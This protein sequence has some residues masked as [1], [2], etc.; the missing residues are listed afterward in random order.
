M[1]FT[2]QICNAQG[3]ICHAERIS[4]F[5]EPYLQAIENIGEG[6]K[7]PKKLKIYISIEKIFPTNKEYLYC[8]SNVI[9][10][11][12]EHQTKC[13]LDDI[14]VSAD[15]IILNITQ[16]VSDRLKTQ[17]LSNGIEFFVSWTYTNKISTAAQK[18][19]KYGSIQLICP[20]GISRQMK[21]L[22]GIGNI[23]HINERLLIRAD[24]QNLN[25]IFSQLEYNT[26]D[27]GNLK[28]INLVNKRKTI[29]I[30][31]RDFPDRL[32]SFDFSSKEK[33]EQIISGCKGSRIVIIG[34][35]Q[36]K[37]F[38]VTSISGEEI[39]KISI[40]D[41]LKLQV[42]YNLDMILLGC[43]TAYQGATSGTL[44]TIRPKSVLERLKTT[45]NSRNAKDFLDSLSF[46]IF[47]FL[48]DETL[49]YN[50]SP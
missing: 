48:I 27:F 39:F 3:L 41:L 1:T 23:I 18:F 16:G 25:L 21:Y 28:V 36:D 38:S 7:N 10:S 24:L 6:S 11:G 34:H 22:R 15:D 47:K 20:D 44:N 37:S 46:G 45:E 30:M 14:R 50:A 32:I 5:D 31:Q 4:G 33:F 17:L 40:D 42:K 49:F 26:I 29:D 2:A 13:A 8:Q 9:G 35:I 12:Y 19:F 43:E